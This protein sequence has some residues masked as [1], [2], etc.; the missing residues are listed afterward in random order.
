MILMEFFYNLNELLR[1]SI[2]ISEPHSNDDHTIIP[3]EV[4]REIDS[5][6]PHESNSIIPHQTSLDSNSITLSYHHSQ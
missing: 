6:I 2:Q 4:P 3:H 1:N 5:L